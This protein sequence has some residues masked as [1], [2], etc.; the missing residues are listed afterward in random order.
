MARFNH[1]WRHAYDFVTV[2]CRQDADTFEATTSISNHGCRSCQCVLASHRSFR[3]PSSDAAAAG[4]D[5]VDDVASTFRLLFRHPLPL[6]SV[7]T[8]A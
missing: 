1:V 7:A 6:C 8:T 5:S 2:T 4:C 3:K